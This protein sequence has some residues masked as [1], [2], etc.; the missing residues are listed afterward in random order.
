RLYRQPRQHSLN[1]DGRLGRRHAVIAEDVDL[2]RAV[3]LLGDSMQACERGRI[4]FQDS[5]RR[6]A[7]V[8]VQMQKIIELREVK[9]IEFSLSRLQIRLD[10]C[11]QLV[12]GP[13]MVT[14]RS[15]GFATILQQVENRGRIR[16]SAGRVDVALL[17]YVQ[18]RQITQ[19]DAVKL[20]VPA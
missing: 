7:V 12:I 2:R 13:V 15:V 6:L 19:R 20:E 18:L 16:N 4:F 14:I 9:K 11:Q 1:I 5:C 10:A 3:G 17:A 8:G